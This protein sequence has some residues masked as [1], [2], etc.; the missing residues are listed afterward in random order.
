MGFFT[1]NRYKTWRK[2][3][4]EALS[5]SGAFDSLAP[6]RNVA[7]ECVK[8]MVRDGVIGL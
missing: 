8:D 5:Y 1:E 7:I 4:L 6:T 3:S 2:K